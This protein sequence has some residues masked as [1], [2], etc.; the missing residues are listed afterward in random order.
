VTIYSNPEKYGLRT[1]GEIDWTDELYEFDLTVVWITPYG[2]LYWGNDTGCSCPEPFESFSLS[3]LSTGTFHD[4]AE[5]LNARA[6][7][8]NR[9]VQVVELLDRVRNYTRGSSEVD[10][11]Q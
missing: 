1:I 5:H 4:L 11:P 10:S 7:E 9:D 8:A 2:V 3:D 6:K